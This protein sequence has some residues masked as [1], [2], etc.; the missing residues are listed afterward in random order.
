LESLPVPEDVRP[1]GDHLRNVL[2]LAREYSL[3]ACD[4]AYLE[5]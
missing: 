1:V 4:A 5:L 3:S 2:P